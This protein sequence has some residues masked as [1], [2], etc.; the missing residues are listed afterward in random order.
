MRFTRSYFKLEALWILAFTL[1]PVLVG[2]LIV[3]L[4]RSLR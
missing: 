4:L 3:L 1:A 2:L